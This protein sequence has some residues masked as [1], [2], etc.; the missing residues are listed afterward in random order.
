MGTW[1]SA[2]RDAPQI[3]FCSLKPAGFQSPQTELFPCKAVNLQAISSRRATHS[4]FFSV[5]VLPGSFWI[6]VPS[7]YHQTGV[8]DA[9]QQAEN[10][11]GAAFKSFYLFFQPCDLVVLKL[12]YKDLWDQWKVVFK[13]RALECS[14]CSGRLGA[15][16]A[17]LEMLFDLAAR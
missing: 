13:S 14:L 16:Q 12:F 6:L 11:A 7:D 2:V 8:R 5:F 10:A 17:L 9:W 1:W 3:C 4:T 15:W